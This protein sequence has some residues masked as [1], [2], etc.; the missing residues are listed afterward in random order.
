MCFSKINKLV[1]VHHNITILIMLVKICSPVITIVE[2]DFTIHLLFFIENNHKYTGIKL[3]FISL[4]ETK[5]AL[6]KLML[7]IIHIMLD[8]IF[9]NMTVNI[10]HV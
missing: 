4:Q 1:L 6:E 8:L 5:N 10:L 7:R 9:K 3:V 2:S